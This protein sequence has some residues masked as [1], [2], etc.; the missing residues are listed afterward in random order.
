MYQIFIYLHLIYCYCVSVLSHFPSYENIPFYD[1]IYDFVSDIFLFFFTT[2]VIRLFSLVNFEFFL[3][4][5]LLF[6]TRGARTR[7]IVYNRDWWRRSLIDRL[8]L[9]RKFVVELIT[10]ETPRG[11]LRVSVRIRI[12][13]LIRYQNNNKQKYWLRSNL[14]SKNSCIHYVKIE[15]QKPFIV[16]GW[17]IILESFIDNLFISDISY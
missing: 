16:L 8:R 17:G 1:G 5:R 11:T 15:R 13:L 9:G 7:I 4:V 12:F 6:D 3:W 10:E 2:T 14:K